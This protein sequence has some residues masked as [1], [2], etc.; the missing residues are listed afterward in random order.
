MIRAGL[1]MM[2]KRLL[3]Q[4]FQTTAYPYTRHH[5]DS[6]N[7]F[8]EI[9]LPTIIKS[10]NPL[11][12][13]KDLI[14]GTNTYEYTVEIY[15]GG[16]DGKSLHLGTPT[17]QTNEDVRLLF[18]NEARLRNLTYSAGLYADI[19]VRVKFAKPVEGQPSVRE[20]LLPQFPLV[21]IRS[22]PHT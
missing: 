7:Q 3:D 21:E 17:I 11:I 1:L 6:Y 8:L 20:V 15:V 18:P 2:P 5:L 4:Y 10:Q 14:K 19:L 9:D 13:V 12:I 16:L 22:Y